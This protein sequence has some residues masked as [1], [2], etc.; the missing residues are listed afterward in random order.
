MSK[1]TKS[2]ES[3]SSSSE[4]EN[5]KV[6]ERLG[7]IATQSAA[8]NL[9]K[10]EAKVQPKGEL[11]ST[12]AT[13]SHKPESK[14]VRLEKAETGSNEEQHG[15]ESKNDRSARQADLKKQLLLALAPANETPES[16]GDHTTILANDLAG[17][18]LDLDMSG[19]EI[20]QIIKTINLENLPVY[21][22]QITS[23]KE[24]LSGLKQE[25]KTNNKQSGEELLEYTEDISDSVESSTT[26]H[27]SE[28]RKKQENNTNPESE[29]N[30][31]INE[32]HTS[33]YRQGSDVE[34]ESE[35][36]LGAN[37]ETVDDDDKQTIG[38]EQESEAELIDDES[39]VD[40]EELE[41]NERLETNKEAEV[42]DEPE[43]DKEAEVNDE[44]ET[45]AEQG[46]GAGLDDDKE[47]GAD[48]E[49]ESSEEYESSDKLESDDERDSSE[50][51]KLIKKQNYDEKQESDK[52]RLVGKD[53]KGN[54]AEEIEKNETTETGEE[55]KNKTAP[56]EKPDIN[57]KQNTR[58][59][60][61]NHSREIQDKQEIQL[62]NIDQEE[63]VDNKT[64]EFEIKK[65]ESVKKIESFDV[66]NL[67][68]ENKKFM[69][70]TIQDYFLET[71]PAKPELVKQL[72]ER[73]SILDGDEYNKILHETEEDLADDV[74]N[75]RGFYSPKHNRVFINQSAHKSPGSLFAT[76]FHESLHFVSLG[77]GSGLSGKFM[78]PPEI[79][80]QKE[81]SE[82]I[83][84]GLD[85]LKEGTTQLITLENVLNKML[86][87]ADEDM[88]G[89]EP[90]GRIMEVA[91]GPF[92]E[93]E[94]LHAYFEMSMEDLRI[95][96]EKTFQ[97]TE[98]R[99]KINQNGT[100]GIFADCL[101][102]LGTTTS[103]MRRALETW[104]TGGDPEA[105]MQEVRRA[106]NYYVVRRARMREEQA[107][108][109][110]ELMNSYFDF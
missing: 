63:A 47:V 52:E 67:S 46:F 83:D 24:F 57:E 9:D 64:V 101:A 88:F 42:N 98:T 53:Y 48:A 96:I 109:K 59:K 17:K 71:F 110:G 84:N 79:E 11:R 22:E 19:D 58:E 108:K 102:K 82:Q 69:I 25:I 62:N 27:T 44:P 94:K 81:T 95:N 75:M 31:R 13:S 60:F 78:C 50:K 106:V 40:D 15:S 86:F 91:W 45:D 104:E 21:I 39:L 16:L 8:E 3:F 51:E 7:S 38:D 87:D 34:L 107:S 72:P 43:T 30:Q 89:Y 41:A 2:P 76:V 20:A 68:P 85:T 32:K 93:E 26:V 80:S 54:D 90:E 55:M 12:S 4:Y 28:T 65:P 103:E 56:T 49:L 99:N 100:N 97:T 73:I 77:A 105:V 29:K 5:H 1:L 35:D 14:D 66:N 70:N 61:K 33:N 10:N 92:A 6:I 23:P 18:I 74:N 36:D 37:D